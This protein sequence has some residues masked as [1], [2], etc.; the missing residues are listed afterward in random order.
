MFD[1]GDVSRMKRKGAFWRKN[2][3]DLSAI[4][5]QLKKF[6]LGKHLS[7]HGSLNGYWTRYVVVEQPAT[8]ERRK[9]AKADAAGKFFLE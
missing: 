1:T 5:E 6:E 2:V 8:K 4:D 3:I 9:R 7:K